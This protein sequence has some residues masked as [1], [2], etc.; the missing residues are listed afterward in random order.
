MVVRS[1]QAFL[2]YLDQKRFKSSVLDKFPHIKRALQHET[3]QQ[4]KFHQERKSLVLAR[5][6]EISSS[7]AKPPLAS[8]SLIKKA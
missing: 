2:L 4:A 8:T 7:C 3:L 1:Q 5:H 6:L